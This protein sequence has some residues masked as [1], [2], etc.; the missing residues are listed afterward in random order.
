MKAGK[1]PVSQLFNIAVFNGIVVNVV[2][3]SP[4]ILFAPNT[5]IPIVVPKLAA[6]SFVLPV[7]GGGCTSMQ[8]FKEK[9][10]IFGFLKVE[11]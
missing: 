4:V 6:W 2:K 1:G 8:L 3:S 11:Q 7:E 10:Q 5:S 9:S